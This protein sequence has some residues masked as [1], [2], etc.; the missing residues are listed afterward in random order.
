MGE[1]IVVFCTVPSKEVASAIADALVPSGRAACVNIISGIESVYTWKGEVCRDAESL[2][3]IKSRRDLFETI[4]QTIISIHP[5]EV[6]EIISLSIA[7]GH[8]PY[9]TWIEETTRKE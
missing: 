4:R 7:E 2:L 9:L 3:I 6:P 8:D 1:K 5:Y